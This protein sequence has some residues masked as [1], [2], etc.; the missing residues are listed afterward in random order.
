MRKARGIG[1]LLLAL[2]TAGATSSYAA[3]PPAPGGPV[4]DFELPDPEGNT[5]RL[6]SLKGEVVV[7]HFWATWCPHCLAEMPV[8]AQAARDPSLHGVRI[9]AINLGEPAKVVSRYLRS[10]SL[11][12]PVLLDSRGKVAASYGV[13]GLPVSLVVDASG[14]LAKQ[15]SMGSLSREELARS[16]A[17]LLERKEGTEGGEGPRR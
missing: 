7:L 5:L 2:L 13:V 4:P 6:S 11:D 14:R 17:P 8:L 12:L 15:I 16:L 9:L 3:A 10:H 1:I